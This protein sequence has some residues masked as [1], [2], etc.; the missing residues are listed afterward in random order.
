[1]W[2]RQRK[3]T[4]PSKVVRLNLSH[5]EIVELGGLR[6]STD[7]FPPRLDPMLTSVSSAIPRREAS[8]DFTQRTTQTPMLVRIRSPAIDEYCAWYLQC[9]QCGIRAWSFSMDQGCVSKCG[10]NDHYLSTALPKTHFHLLLLRNSAESTSD[11]FLNVN[12][13]SKL[14]KLLILPQW[15]GCALLPPSFTIR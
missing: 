8:L 15:S 7:V 5:F 1:M 9:R 10:V 12:I 14:L 13:D 6:I 3:D 11:F 4:S 2:I